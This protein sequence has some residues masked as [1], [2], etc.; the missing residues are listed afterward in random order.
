MIHWIEF[1]AQ[2]SDI[3]HFSHKNSSSG[4]NSLCFDTDLGVIYFIFTKVDNVKLAG[5]GITFCDRKP[6]ENA[7]EYAESS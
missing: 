4:N 5:L 3:S 2:I 1:R 7:W 6:L